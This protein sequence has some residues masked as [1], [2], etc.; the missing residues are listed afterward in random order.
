MERKKILFIDQ[1]EVFHLAVQHLLVGYEV[2]CARDGVG[3]LLLLAREK[4]VDLILSDQHI[5]N[6][7]GTTLGKKV[8]S[9]PLTKEIPFVLWINFH[10]LNGEIMKDC[11]ENSLYLIEKNANSLNEIDCWFKKTLS[12]LA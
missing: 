7:N 5:G 6:I 2:V 10:D 9:N 4:D 1:S 3:A 8:K 12:E 11:M